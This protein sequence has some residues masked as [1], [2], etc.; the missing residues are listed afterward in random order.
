MNERLRIVVADDELD[1][2][3]YYQHALP[4]LGHEVVGVASTGEELT[5][6]CLTLKPDL[7]VTDISMP[8]MDG[9]DAATSVN[10]QLAVPVV[11]VSAYHDPELIERAENERIAAYLVKPIKQADLAPAIGLAVRRFA[12]F[13]A[14]RKEAGDLRQSLDD[15]KVIERAKGVLMQKAALAETDAFRRMQKLARDQNRKLVD[16][17]QMILAAEQAFRPAGERH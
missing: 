2:R 5:Q 14:L 10:R 16:V 17:A 9:I 15:R 11:L 13:E 8:G 12:E 1:M 4:I 3:E 6:L 7:I